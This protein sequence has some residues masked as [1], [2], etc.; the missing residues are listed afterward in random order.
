MPGQ[1]PQQSAVW[2]ERFSRCWCCWQSAETPPFLSHNIPPPFPSPLNDTPSNPPSVASS[3]SSNTAGLTTRVEPSAAGPITPVSRRRSLFL[4]GAF[5]ALL[6]GFRWWRSIRDWWRRR[7][8]QESPDAELAERGRN[9]NIIRAAE[10][11]QGN[12][13]SVSAPIV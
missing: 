6:F 12:G 2:P 1:K 11:G 10:V 13:A 3:A 7:S 9:A 5:F 4:L 8:V